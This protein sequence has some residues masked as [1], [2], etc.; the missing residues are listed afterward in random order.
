MRMKREQDTGRSI[1]TLLY[2]IILYIISLV[3]GWSVKDGG[4]GGGE[5]TKIEMW[6]GRKEGQREV[7]FRRREKGGERERKSV[8]DKIRW[9]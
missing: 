7:H 9:A 8:Q 5:G 2:Y 1:P 6:R 4:K 3:A